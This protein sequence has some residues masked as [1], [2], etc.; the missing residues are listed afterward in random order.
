MQKIIFAALVI[1][2][3][4]QVHSKSLER[5]NYPY[6][7]LTEDYGILNTE[8]L[9]MNSCDVDPVPFSGEHASYSYWKCFPISKTKFTCD[10]TGNDHK[11]KEQNAVQIITVQDSDSEHFYMPRKAADVKNCHWFQ[12]RWES[13]I[14]G[15]KFVCLSGAFSGYDAENGHRTSIWTFDKFKTKK[16]CQSYFHGGCSLNYAKSHG[17]EI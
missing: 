17:C 5:K 11:L 1:L 3:L 6:A 4:S 16:S 10:T 8:D 2:N 7:L 14:K 15:E 9:A 13:S 12:K